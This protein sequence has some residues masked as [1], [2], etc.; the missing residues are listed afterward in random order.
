MNNKNSDIII[1]SGYNIEGYRIKRYINYISAVTVLGTGFSNSLEATVAE[2]TGSR[3]SG[4]EEKLSEAASSSIR[5]LKRRASA[6]GANAI[7]GL[8]VD[9]CSRGVSGVIAGGTAI[10]C[11]ADESQYREMYVYNYNTALPFNISCIGY[12]SAGAGISHI[13][14]KGRVYGSNTL[15]AIAATIDLYTI[16]G[17]KLSPM[18]VIFPKII[19]NQYGAFKTTPVR[20]QSDVSVFDTVKKAHVYVNKYMINEDTIISDNK[21]NHLIS[22][23]ASELQ[24]LR[25]SLNIDAVRPNSINTDIWECCCGWDN[26]PGAER[27]CRCY[28]TP[29]GAMEVNGTYM[30]LPPIVTE[31]G[32]WECPCCGK[33]QQP[34]EKCW[35]C[36]NTFYTEKT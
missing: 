11:E 29:S 28:R 34:R 15:S 6:I 31:N 10:L 32:M 24:K 25:N 3:S 35:S 19:R 16:F 4:Y 26:V 2:F 30:F 18:N 5:E 22:L 36:G 13:Y 20:V 27:C 17:D 33:L 8:D 12:R 14:L 7:I 21:D 23:S 9:Y 1:T